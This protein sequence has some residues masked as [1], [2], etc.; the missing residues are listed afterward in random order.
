MAT[1]IALYRTPASVLDTWMQMPEDERKKGMEEMEQKWNVWTA[2]HQGALK[3][4]AGAGKT[5]RLTKAGVEDVRNDIMMYSMVE[6]ESHEAAVKL[7]EGHPHFDIPESS[8]DVMPANP[9]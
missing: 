1:F 5:K 7:F 9:V 6:A 2:A 3:E 4:T 8:I